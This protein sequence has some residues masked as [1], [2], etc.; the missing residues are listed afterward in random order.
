MKRCLLIA[1]AV[2]LL[3][4]P[5]A[6]EM[7]ASVYKTYPG[8]TRLVFPAETLFSYGLKVEASGSG[9]YLELTSSSPVL[10]EGFAPVT[11]EDGVVSRLDMSESGGKKSIMI[12]LGSGYQS[13][14]SFLVRQPDRLVVEVVG[15]AATKEYA[16]L[17]VV[18]LDAGHGGRDPGAVGLSGGTEKDLCL[19]MAS[20]VRKLLEKEGARVVM[21][22]NADYA[23]P[24]MERASI[25]HQNKGG[26]FLSIHATPRSTGP[27]A[28]RIYVQDWQFADRMLEGSAAPDKVKPHLWGVQ[29]SRHIF[30]SG[31][32]AAAVA[33]ELGGG[34]DD[35]RATT[36]NVLPS[37][38]LAALDMPAALVDVADSAEKE[39]SLSSEKYRQKIAEK[40]ARGITAAISR[41]A[42]PGGIN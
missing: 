34:E 19:D 41:F 20:R 36:L 11:I 42:E 23:L 32:L 18:V 37:P 39:G 29:Q 35:P 24:H 5:A 16:W 25:A 4:V 31:I 9:R 1:V 7:T 33:R 26:L 14:R 3:A 8:F 22:R 27:E 12:V 38:L 30:R 15:R 2:L 17:P 6:A 28:A 40:I 13:Y 10:F 21:T